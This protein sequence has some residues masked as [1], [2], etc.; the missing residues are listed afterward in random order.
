MLRVYNIDFKSIEFRSVP[1]ASLFRGLLAF[2]NE[3][4]TSLIVIIIYLIFI[5]ILT[6]IM[7]RAS[8]I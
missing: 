4:L 2:I 3:N 6:R 7:P 1:K 8:T 5:K